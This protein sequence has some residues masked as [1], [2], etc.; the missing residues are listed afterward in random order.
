VSDVPIAKR[1]RRTARV[2]LIRAGLWLAG[3]LPFRVAWAIGG[4]VGRAA[5][6]VARHDRALA[7]EHLAIAFPDWTEAE[8]RRVARASFLHFGHSAA[9]VAQI[10]RIDARLEAYVTYAGDGERQLRQASAAG[11]GFVFVTG[12]LGNWELLA[13]RI[14]RSSV[15]SIVIAA[16]SWDR[17]IDDLVEAFR[18]SGGVPTLFREDAR[19]GRTLLR[20][21]REGKALGILIDQDTKV[22]GVHVPFFGRAAFTPRAAADLAIRFGCPVYVGWSRR[23]GPRPGDG[24]VLEVEPVDYDPAAADREAEALRLTAACTARLEQAIRLAP[25]EWVWMHRRWRTRPP[26]EAAARSGDAAA[27][28]P[29]AP[30]R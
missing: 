24:Y 26:V 29:G 7:L 12:H 28:G 13:R 30:A 15:P 20:S 27:A 10:R 6:L 21:M 1:V 5:W 18:A 14:V 17:R 19:G 25:A 2:W 4:A 11:K 23:S 8:R 16:R 3:R 22:Q 9:E